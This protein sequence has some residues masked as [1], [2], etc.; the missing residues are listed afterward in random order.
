[1]TATNGALYPNMYSCLLILITIP[2]TIAT[3]E[4]SFSIMRGIETYV[5]ST[6]LIE[7]LWSYSLAFQ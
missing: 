3:A 6:M 4:R 2:V 5:Q 7:R 1:M